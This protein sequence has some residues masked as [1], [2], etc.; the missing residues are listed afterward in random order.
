MKNN[1][2]IVIL[3]GRDS[4]GKPVTVDSALSQ[5]STNPV[6]NQAIYQALAN[7][8]DIQTSI[9]VSG[10]TQTIEPQANT[11]YNCGELTSLTISNPPATG[12]FG[13]IFYSGATA[14]VVTGIDN[15]TVEANKRYQIDVQDGYAKLYSWPYTP[16][17]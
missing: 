8:E 15:F 7:K 9:A 12:A 2:E 11:I 14:T 16:T 3:A 6:Q 1:K 10:T 13:I 17:P 5:S 4:G